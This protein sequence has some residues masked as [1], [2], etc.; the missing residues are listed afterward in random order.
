MSFVFGR[1]QYSSGRQSGLQLVFQGPALD[2]LESTVDAGQQL[3]PGAP[4]VFELDLRSPVA[5]AFDLA[6]A[7][8]LF[9]PVMP[10]GVDLVDVHSSGS[11]RVVIEGRVSDQ[12]EQAQ[13][14][15]A[16]QGF[17]VAVLPIIGWIGT[18]WLGISLI[19][20]GLFVSLAFLISAVRGKSVISGEPL[21]DTKDLVK[22]GA[23]GLIAVGLLQ[24]VPKR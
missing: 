15:H 13:P 14:G 2:R 5:R 9:R 7:E 19:S 16:S 3:Q 23:I 10:P 6:G 11:S 22:W 18:H 1:R 21:N 20:I 24:L 12:A 8:S 4:V 17:A